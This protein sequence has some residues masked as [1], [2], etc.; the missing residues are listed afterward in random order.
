MPQMQLVLSPLGVVLYSFVDGTR[1][2][3]PKL[4]ETEADVLAHALWLEKH[5][6]SERAE[7][8]LEEYLRKN[9][10]YTH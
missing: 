5:G 8:Y 9:S 4:R 6:A 7:E 3:R 2:A 10:G 1:V